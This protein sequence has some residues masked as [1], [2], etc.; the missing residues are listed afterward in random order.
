MPLEGSYSAAIHLQKS[1]ETP[2]GVCCQRESG[3]MKLAE[4]ASRRCQNRQSSGQGAAEVT[5]QEQGCEL[6][7]GPAAA[8]RSVHRQ[9]KERG[10]GRCL[11]TALTKDRAAAGAVSTHDHRLSRG[12]G[13]ERVLALGRRDWR[14]SHVCRPHAQA[15]CLGHLV[16][17]T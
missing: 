5:Q 1:G 2:R 7:I 6:L 12:V 17:G 11:P 9:G 14:W 10:V 13:A 15:P 8:G 16:C 3:D 4:E